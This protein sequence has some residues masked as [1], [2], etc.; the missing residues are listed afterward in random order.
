MVL[1]GV[2]NVSQLQDEMEAEAMSSLTHTASLAVQAIT[3]LLVQ[4]LILPC[5]GNPNNG[6]PMRHPRDPQLSL[7]KKSTRRLFVV[8]D[9]L[10]WKYENRYVQVGCSLK[11]R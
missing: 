1:L 2:L 7:H 6:S 8:Q 3:N 4:T 9:L 5:P 10:L 11:H